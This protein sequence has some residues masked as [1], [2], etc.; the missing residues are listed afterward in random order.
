MRA[1]CLL[2]L[3]LLLLFRVNWI[4]CYW[5]EENWFHNLKLNRKRWKG[6]CYCDVPESNQYHIETKDVVNIESE[7]ML[8]WGVIFYKWQKNALKLFCIWWKLNGEQ[9]YC[10]VPENNW[11]NVDNIEN[12][13]N[14]TKKLTKKFKYYDKYNYF[15]NTIPP[16][17][18][19]LYIW[20]I[21]MGIK[22]SHIIR[23]QK[24]L[25]NMT[26]I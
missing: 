19:V 13:K 9:C 10:G 25:S 22:T 11:N 4:F 17:S 2:L 15:K 23:L 7:K 24:L 18:D 26:S 16:T 8:L 14:V 20:E 6:Q 1:C 21:Y 3:L 5:G 12:Y